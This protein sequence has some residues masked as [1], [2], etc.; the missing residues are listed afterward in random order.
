M[1]I[2]PL[3]AEIFPRGRTDKQTGMTKLT[4]AFP[5]SGT[6]V[7]NSQLCRKIMAVCFENRTQHITTLY[8]P[9]TEIL[10]VTLGCI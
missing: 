8:E 6:R 4:V 3:E 9:D 1:K 2:R 7:K 5:V 10:K